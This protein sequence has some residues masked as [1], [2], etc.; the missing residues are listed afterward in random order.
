MFDNR[1][2]LYTKS[3]TWVKVGEDCRD[4]ADN[5][6]VDVESHCTLKLCSVLNMLQFSVG[7]KKELQTLREEIKTLTGQIQRKL[8]G[9]FLLN[10]RERLFF[11]GLNL[12]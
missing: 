3:R 8:K 1:P 12:P 6:C 9:E 7:M 2:D 10:C 4:L 11:F 5:Q